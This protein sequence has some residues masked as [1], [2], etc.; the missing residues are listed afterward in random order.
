VPDAEAELVERSRQ[1]DRQAFE[2]LVRQTARLVYA[3]AYLETASSH[4]AEDLTQETY[5]RA[6]SRVGQVKDAASFRP[7]LMSILHAVVIDT[8][9]NESRRKRSGPRAAESMAETIQDPRDGPL[10]QAQQSE[11]KMRALA[12]LRGMPAEYREVLMLR[13]VAGADYETI[14]RELAISNGSLRGL[15]HRGLALLRQRLGES[16]KQ[17]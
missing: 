10:A 3:R 2:E 16:E 8:A 17:S 9:R 14:G 6:W 15:L 12:T 5:L 7:W 4:R 1:G 11:Q 13:Y